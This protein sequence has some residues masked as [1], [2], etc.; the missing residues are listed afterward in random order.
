MEVHK[1]YDVEHGWFHID[2]PNDVTFSNEV[3]WYL[4]D[5]E[6]GAAIHVQLA[7][8]MPIFVYAQVTVWAFG[9]GNVYYAADAGSLVALVGKFTPGVSWMKDKHLKVIEVAE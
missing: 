3:V 7:E 8:G 9:M 5:N 2:Y 1:V 4:G 6:E